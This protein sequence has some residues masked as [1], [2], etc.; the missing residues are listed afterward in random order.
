MIGFFPEPY[1]DELLFSLCARY[2]E[3][4]GYQSTRS[5]LTDLFK[6]RRVKLSVDLPTRI[7]TLMSVL[8]PGHYLTIDRLINHHTLV[9]FFTPFVSAPRVTR[10]K[11]QMAGP[12]GGIIHGSLGVNSFAG[13]LKVFRY[14]PNCVEADRA[15]Y[16]ETYW[17]RSHHI[18]AVNICAEHKTYL[19]DT[20]LPLRYSRR[21]TPFITAEASLKE[22]DLTIEHERDERLLMLLATLANNALW[23]LQHPIF[24]GY[25]VNHRNHYVHLFYE[26]GYCT[27]NGVLDRRKLANNFIA[28]YSYR[29][30][31]SMKCEVATDGSEDW[32]NRFVHRKDR[33]IH[34]ICHLL[35]VQFLDQ[36]LESFLT[37][38]DRRTLRQENGEYAKKRVVQTIRPFVETPFGMAP[39]PCLNPASE[40]FQKGVVTIC[41]ISSTQLHPRRPR[42]TFRC[43]CGFAYSR[44]GPDQ[45]EADRYKLDRYVSFGQ[46][47]ENTVR[48]SF[49]KGESYLAISRRL[50]I[51]RAVML[52]QLFRLGLKK[53]TGR[54][55]I[56]VDH[57][58]LSP[59]MLK[60]RRATKRRQF[61]ALR[62]L[63]QK[64][65]RSELRRTLGGLY[66]W[67]YKHDRAWLDNHLPKRQCANKTRKSI[68]Q[69]R[70]AA[71]AAAVRTEANKMRALPGRPVR[72][73]ATSIA[74]NL[75][76]AYVWSKR[77]HVL[78]QTC[79]ALIEVGETRDQLAVRRVEW[80]TAIFEKL[81][82]SPAAWR[83]ALKAGLSGEVA[84]RP[85]VKEAIERAV[86]FLKSQ[87]EFT[88]S[89]NNVVA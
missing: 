22:A 11:E 89:A 87:L 12:C 59:D 30:L 33:L 68:W 63:N 1:P 56:L 77:A 61:L 60:Q 8:P 19:K 51:N 46:C 76:V 88:F 58:R 39:W 81:G 13:K 28:Y 71:L 42:G 14:C 21:R 40:H 2:S 48:E 24:A 7:G 84:K 18:P 65:N 50:R 72:I 32:L 66:Q 49:G 36:N 38:T 80:A 31:E 53:E 55:S 23:L 57:R 79:K 37:A 4:S 6:S 27:Y 73:T 9:P 69:Q 25:Q 45:T 54:V 75:G 5:A 17:H 35:L 44:V 29:L 41:E 52:K 62:K 10:I 47:W 67:L 78:P 83:I 15:S 82:L 26:R 3:M 20:I 16:G 86:D 64:L 34:P 85:V 70:D 74:Y 43:E